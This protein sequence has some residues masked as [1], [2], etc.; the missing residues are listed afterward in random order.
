MVALRI[1]EI[2]SYKQFIT[3]S[4]YVLQQRKIKQD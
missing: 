2:I 1:F 3:Y 4:Q